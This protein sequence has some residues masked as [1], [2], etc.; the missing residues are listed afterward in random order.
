M[1][2]SCNFTMCILWLIIDNQV[3][4]RHAHYACCCSFVHEALPLTETKEVVKWSIC[5][6]EVTVTG[7]VILHKATS[8]CCT[9]LYLK[10]VTCDKF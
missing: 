8:S 7:L 1:I 9:T 4:A 2:S 5:L 3:V 6:Q 10:L